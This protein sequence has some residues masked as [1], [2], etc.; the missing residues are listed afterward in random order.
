MFEHSPLRLPSII[1]FFHRASRSRTFRPII[2]NSVLSSIIPSRHQF[3]PLD[4]DPTAP[5]CRR[6]SPAVYNLP[7][8]SSIIPPCHLSFPSL[9]SIIVPLP[10]VVSRDGSLQQAS[11]RSSPQIVLTGDASHTVWIGRQS[12][13][14]HPTPGHGTL[15][16]YPIARRIFDN[17]VKSCTAGQSR[18]LEQTISTRALA[19]A[20]ASAGT[21]GPAG[22]RWWQLGRRA[23]R[24]PPQQSWGMGEQRALQCLGT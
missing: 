5:S 12:T 2:A 16:P 22:I 10:I 24:Q 15:R 8:L 23:T 11:N 4:I 20:V 13:W 1:P 6:S 3:P 9:S 17:G 18:N 21:L 19:A 14:Q 7:P